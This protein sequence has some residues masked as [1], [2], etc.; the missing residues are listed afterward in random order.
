MVNP[1]TTYTMRI[2]NGGANAEFEPV[3]SGRIELN[4]AEIFGPNDFNQNVGLAEMAVT[5]QASDTLMVDLASAPSGGITLEVIGDDNDLPSITTGI[6]PAPNANGWNN[7]AVTITFTCS[8]T[9]SPIDF[10]SAPVT[11]NVQGTSSVF[12]VVADVAGNANQIIVSA[13]VDLTQPQLSADISPPPGRCAK[14][15]TGSSRFTT[16]RRPRSSGPRR[17]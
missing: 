4:G 12:G 3:S 7:T 6:S 11:I 5:V 14:R 16:P 2:H 9:T 17:R 10:C 1:S 15:L 13:S 8:D